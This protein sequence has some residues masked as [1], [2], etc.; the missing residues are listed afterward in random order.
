MWARLRSFKGIGIQFVAGILSVMVAI[1]VT[2]YVLVL[3]G[4]NLTPVP[5]VVDGVDAGFSGELCPGDTVMT[6]YHARLDDPLV[7]EIFYVIMDEHRHFTYTRLPLGHTFAPYATPAEFSQPV[8]WQVPQ[9][10]AGHYNLAISLWMRGI[11]ADPVNVY[12]PFTISA[13]CARLE[14]P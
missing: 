11:G 9:L 12:V 5:L 3:F 8:W 4:D 6:T 14:M 10:P 7:V 1:A 13:T 2:L